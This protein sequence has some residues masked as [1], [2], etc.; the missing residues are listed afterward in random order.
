[1]HTY[2]DYLLACAIMTLPVFLI[3]YY[4]AWRADKEE[5]D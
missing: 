3:N 5:N 1:M 2:L 4:F